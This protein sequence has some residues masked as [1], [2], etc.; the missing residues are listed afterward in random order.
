MHSTRSHWTAQT[1]TETTPALVGFCMRNCRVLNNN[2]CNNV[3]LD[4]WVCVIYIYVCVFFCICM[5]VSV[6]FYICKYI[7]IY[8]CVF[9]RLIVGYVARRWQRRALNQLVTAATANNDDTDATG[10]C[11]HA[12]CMTVQQ[13]STQR[14]VR[15]SVRPYSQ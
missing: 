3:S 9:V 10:L 2:C 15:P 12:I 5:C 11:S 7:Y 4:V 1:T 8:V 13:H 6:V 14:C